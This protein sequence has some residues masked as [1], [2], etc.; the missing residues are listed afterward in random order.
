MAPGNKKESGDDSYMTLREMVRA[1]LENQEEEKRDRK[2]VSLELIKLSNVIYGDP[3]AK[4][5]GVAHRVKTLELSDKKTTKLLVFVSAISAGL[6][7]GFKT[8]GEHLK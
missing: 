5:P 1:T 3:A 6:A 8:I 4:I 2:I 7:L